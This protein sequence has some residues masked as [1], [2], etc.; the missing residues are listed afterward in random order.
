MKVKKKTIKIKDEIIKKINF[1]NDSKQ[2]MWDDNNNNPRERL[3]I[4]LKVSKNTTLMII[5][6]Q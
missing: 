6:T 1:K 5:N 3:L 2:T 4:F